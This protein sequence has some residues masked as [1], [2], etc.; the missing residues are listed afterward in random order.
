MTP[1]LIDAVK[2]IGLGAA[3]VA[4]IIWISIYLIKRFVD[5]SVG[6][7]TLLVSELKVFMERVR[8]EHEQSS[9]QHEALMDQHKEMIT[10]LGRINGYKHD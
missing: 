5:V 4:T 6:Q 1:E 8:G 3:G 7:L 10:T 9:K 2:E